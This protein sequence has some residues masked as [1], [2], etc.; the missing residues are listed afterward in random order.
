MDREVEIIEIPF[1][2]HWH[3]A[4]TDCPNC[5]NRLLDHYMADDDAHLQFI[6]DYTE[7]VSKK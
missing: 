7:E 2:W 1:D 4:S 6:T 5:L 3:L